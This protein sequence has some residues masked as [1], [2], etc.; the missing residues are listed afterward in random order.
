[1]AYVVSLALSGTW[2]TQ[3]LTCRSQSVVVD[4]YNSLEGPVLSE[5]PQGT[6][7]GPLFFLLV[8]N[9]LG[10][11]CMSRMRLF[12]DNTLIYSTTESYIDAAK[13]QS[14]LTALQEW[15]QKWQVKFNPSK[16]HVSRI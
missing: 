12:A 2:L 15:D 5:V 16:C 1:M 13:L 4:G 14:D 3:W 8:I 10:E 11:D 6:V 9:G 7:L